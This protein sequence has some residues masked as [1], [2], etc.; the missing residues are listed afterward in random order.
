MKARTNPALP[1]WGLAVAIGCMAAFVAAGCRPVTA[2]TSD[3]AAPHAEEARHADEHGHEAHE[4]AIVLSPEQMKNNHISIAEA[5]PGKLSVQLALPGEVKLNADRLAHVVPRIPGVVREVFKNVGDEVK[6][7]EVLAVL[8]SRELADLKAAYLAAQERE[9]LARS[10]YEREKGLW[11]K[12]ISAEQ[13]FLSAKNALAEARIAT[14]TAEQK[15]HAIGFSEEYVTKL[16]G[17]PHASLTRF[18]IAAPFD[19]EIIEKHITLGEALKEDAPIFA[20]AD[21]STVWMDLSVYQKDLASLR[22]G[23]EVVISGGGSLENGVPGIISYIGSVMGQETRTATARVVLENRDGHWRPGQFV[24]GFTSVDEV[25]VGVL[26]SKSAI[27]TMQGKSTVFVET[28]KGLVPVAVALG[29]SNDSHAEVL[30]GLE[31]GRRYAA[32]G[33]FLLKAYLEKGSLEHEH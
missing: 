15:L 27:Q 21:L 19:G 32:D 22:K 25:E 6:T 12:K 17:E 30:E 33:A 24:T 9:E 26:I 1:A 31:A 4:E 18:E 8:D 14:R 3:T 11:E 28:E 23:Q 20:V 29:R 10:T 2:D 13:D 16:S 5:G 7:G